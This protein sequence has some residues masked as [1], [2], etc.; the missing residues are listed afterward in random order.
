MVETPT[1]TAFKTSEEESVEVDAPL[2]SNDDL[3]EKQKF[4]TLET[5]LFL[6]K[7]PPITAKLRTAVKHLRAVGG[8]WARFRGLQ[9]A[10]LYNIAYAFLLNFIGGHR[11]SPLR[12]FAAVIVSVVLFRIDLLWT[13]IVIKSPSSKPWY[14]RSVQISRKKGIL[15]T[16][17]ACAAAQE[18]A[19]YLPIALGSLATSAYNGTFTY[20]DFTGNDDTQM[21]AAALGGI[22]ALS[23]SLISVFLVVI[24]AQVTLTRVQASML[25][26][27]DET[28]VPFDRSFGGRMT[29]EI[30]GG[31]GCVGMLDAWRSFDKE[32]RFRLVKLYLKII[33]IQ[34]FAA[35]SFVMTIVCEL[36]V[37]MGARDFNHFL[38][39]IRD[40]GVNSGP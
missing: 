26:D 5:E 6:V 7:Q 27:E 39:N 21:R 14:R 9:V 33:A 24:P 1:A 28:I 29:P 8:R 16:T 19:L 34:I 40:N 3:S 37:V 18:L 30:L 2:V 31:N 36:R 12:P 10:I 13:H 23:L 22:V 38:R 25:S 35:I 15:V 17:A 11:M 32:A 4:K 20:G